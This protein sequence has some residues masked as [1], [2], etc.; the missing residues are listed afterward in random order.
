MNKLKNI[1]KN[2]PFVT[3]FYKLIFCYP[4]RVLNYLLYL[5]EFC[6]FRSQ[7][8]PK[9]FPVRWRDR[10]PQLKEKT[11]TTDFDRHYVYH[12]AWATRILAKTMP[13]K[14]VDISST[15]KFVSL[16]SAFI[17][18]KFYDYRPA[19]LDLSGLDSDFADV[20]DLSFKDNSIQSLSCMHVVEHVGLGRY[21]DKID[22]DGD[23]RAISELQRVLAVGGDLLFVVPI[24]QAMVRYNANRIYSY[25]Q[26]MDY[27]KDLKLVE[28]TLIPDKAKDGG[29]VKDASKE[30]SDAQVQGCGCFWFKK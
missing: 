27:F 24:G 9:R 1:A 20:S 30:L 22:P 6:Q 17:P 19:Q 8:N 21:G 13:K 16:I 3:F 23:L 25:D 5:K 4:R 2:I 10:Q 14:H 28:F 7:N 15:V 12:P 26:I 11:S 18:T 29:L